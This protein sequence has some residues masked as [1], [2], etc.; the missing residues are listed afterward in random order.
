MPERRARIEAERNGSGR[1]ADP[2]KVGLLREDIV[3]L[4]FRPFILGVLLNDGH[5]LDEL[6]FAVGIPEGFAQRREVTIY[7]RFRDRGPFSISL[8]PATFQGPDFEGF[9][10][11]LV[12]FVEPTIGPRTIVE[13]LR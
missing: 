12:D 5:F 4:A 8:S 7:R 11:G 9:D 13:E 1:V 10:L 6:Q 2:F 3:G